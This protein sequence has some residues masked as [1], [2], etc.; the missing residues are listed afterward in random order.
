MI[1]LNPVLTNQLTG[2]Q[3]VLQLIEDRLGELEQEKTELT[4]YEGLDR[5][6]RAIDIALY[7]KQHSKVGIYTML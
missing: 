3:E 4:E 5:Q 6:R 1:L 2:S 7:E